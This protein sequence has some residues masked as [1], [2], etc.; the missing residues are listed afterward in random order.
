MRF[1]VKKFGPSGWKEY[2]VQY[3]YWPFW[4]TFCDMWGCD[5]SYDSLTSAKEVLDSYISYTEEV[6]YHGPSS[7]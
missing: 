6:I 2:Y 4:F 5:K 1:R 3:K 7:R